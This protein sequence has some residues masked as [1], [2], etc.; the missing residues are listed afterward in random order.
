MNSFVRT[1]FPYLV[2]AA[3]V[4]GAVVNVYNAAEPPAQRNREPIRALWRRRWLAL[5]MI[6]GGTGIEMHASA[7]DH[8]G[9]GAA[10]SQ[11]RAAFT[12]PM[13]APWVNDD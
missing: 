2:A 8:S 10:S 4:T 1:G 11:C 13:S 5:A 3:N 12:I 6:V 7:M 9:Q